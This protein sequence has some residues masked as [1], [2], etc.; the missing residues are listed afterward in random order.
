METHFG[1]TIEKIRLQKGIPINH[2]ILDI[3]DASTYHRFKTG[4]IDTSVSKF[5]ALL[6][7]LNIRFEEFLFIDRNFKKDPLRHSLIILQNSFNSKDLKQLKKLYEETIDTEWVNRVAQ[8]H[9]TELLDIY[10]NMLEGKSNDIEN[11]ELIQYLKTVETWSHYEIAMFSNSLKILPTELIDYFLQYMFRS[12]LIYQ[13]MDNYQEEMS[14]ILIQAIITFLS[15]GKVSL[16]RKW[17]D[18][19]RS[20]KI[21]DFL[22]FEKFFIKLLSQYLAAGEG[23]KLS[24]QDL[25]KFEDM[26]KW[27]DCKGFAHNIENMN[28]WIVSFYQTE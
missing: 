22:L 27:L 10:M 15:H 19:L 25:K 21:S 9:L 28:Q 13:E 23:D 7:R 18:Q 24:S 17:Y 6:D 20:Q 5:V 4:K 12:F 8:K 1:K 26:L 11:I 16:A 3:M 14:R 2:F